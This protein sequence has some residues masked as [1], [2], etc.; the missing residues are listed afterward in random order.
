[1]SCGV[2]GLNQGS[3]SEP[4]TVPAQETQ[5]QHVQQAEE[6]HPVPAEDRIGLGAVTE[7]RQLSVVTEPEPA[8]H[9]DHDGRQDHEPD[10]HP[11]PGQVTAAVEL[12]SHPHVGAPVH[13]KGADPYH[14]ER[15]IH[16]R[17]LRER[18]A[19]ALHGDLLLQLTVG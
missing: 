1:M 13:Q 5:L 7:G 16:P 15:E 10:Q 12:R 4:G 11:E 8:E 9:L 19:L 18:A 2:L 3:G 14:R 17:V 6:R